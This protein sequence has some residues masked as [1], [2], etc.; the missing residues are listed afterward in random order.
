MST[1]EKSLVIATAR[2]RV[3]LLSTRLQLVKCELEIA[4]AEMVSLQAQ[5]EGR[6]AVVEPEQM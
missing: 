5:L 1:L 4:L 3:K 2:E 6:P